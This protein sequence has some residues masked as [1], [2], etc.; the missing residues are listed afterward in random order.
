MIGKGNLLLNI[1]RDNPFYITVHGHGL[2]HS[3]KCESWIGLSVTDK[4]VS[5]LMKTPDE[6]PKLLCEATSSEFFGNNIGIE[7]NFICTYWLSYD[8]DGMVLKYG[9]GYRME[10]TTILKHDFNCHYNEGDK[11]KIRNVFFSPKVDRY[12]ELYNEKPLE[13][14]S[15]TASSESSVPAS[16]IDNVELEV[17]FEPTPIVTDL[18]YIVKDSSEVDLFYLDSDKYIY[19][20]SLPPECQ[21]LYDNITA[22]NVDLDYQGTDPKYQYDFKLSDAIRYSI[23]T[24][25]CTLNTKLKS[26]A[27]EFGDDPK[28]AYLRITMGK[29]RGNSPGI[30]YVLELWPKGHCSPIH[31]HGNAYGVIRVLH[32]GLTVH[33]YNKVSVSVLPG[34]ESEDCGC[35]GES[36]VQKLGEFPV[37]KGDV[38]WISPNW[39]QTHK[40]C[41]NT[42]DYCATVQCYQYGNNDYMNWPYFDYIKTCDIIGGFAPNSDYTFTEMFNRVMKEYADRPQPN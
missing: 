42:D 13:T 24:E 9:K 12:V 10:K 15:L 6:E 34:D 3:L 25:G 22:A 26:K 18:S 11:D 7:P 29:E 19:S 33:Y 16:A 2:G 20:A 21:V 14:P 32:G 27:N 39:Y 1:N 17:A 30:P 38:T 40:L 31:N 37:K 8:R 41:N 35:E 5:F 28:L 4:R 23:E 36:H